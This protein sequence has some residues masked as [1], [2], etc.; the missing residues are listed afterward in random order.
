MIQDNFQRY[1]RQTILP[2]FGQESQ[3]KLLNSSCLVVGAGGLGSPV[4]LYLASAGIGKI[5]IVDFDVVDV[6]NLQRQIIHSEERINQNKAKSA[7]KTVEL[8]N[9]EI[10][11]EIFE[12]KITE[13]NANEII[14]KFDIV[15]SCVD[16]YDSRYE[17][18]K[19]CSNLN[20]PM[21]SG[22]VNGWQGQ[23]TT[24]CYKDGPCFNCLYPEK[25]KTLVETNGIIGPVAGFIGSLQAIE[26]IKI[27]IGQSPNYHLKMGIFDGENGNFRIMKI[28][29]KQKNCKVCGIKKEEDQK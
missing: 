16:S 3:Q 26:T 23:I 2:N 28:R 24:L 29:G 17:I 22:S 6:S 25:P 13:E 15:V 20:K 19:V 12:E 21:I 7:Q 18:N 4:I 27:L 1:Q 10:K 9:S 14:S 5:G 11:C 8:L